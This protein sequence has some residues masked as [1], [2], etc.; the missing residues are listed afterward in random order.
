M[1]HIEQFQETEIHTINADF[2]QIE[3]IVLNLGFNSRDSMPEGGKLIFETKNV[4]LDE[5]FCKTNPGAFPGDYVLIKVSDTGC[6][7][8]KEM[9]EH[10]FE[11]FYTTKEKYRGCGLGLAMVYGIVKGHDGYITCCSEPGLGTTFSLY[12]PAAEKGK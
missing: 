6:G 9:M 12:F 1:I 3:Q 2:I 4:T 8:D 11:P 5:T 7:M 10:I